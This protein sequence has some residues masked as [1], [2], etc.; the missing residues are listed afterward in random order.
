MT[1]DFFEHNKK[2]YLVVGLNTGEILFYDEKSFQIEEEASNSYCIRLSLQKEKV[3]QL[4]VCFPYMIQANSKGEINVYD[5]EE[6]LSNYSDE[7]INIEI[8]ENLYSFKLQSNIVF[9]QANL[10]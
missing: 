9:F 8:Y 3:N 10:A 7:K 6:I 2:N 1:A 4:K 5:I